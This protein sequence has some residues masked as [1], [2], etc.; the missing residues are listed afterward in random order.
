MR[1]D[2]LGEGCTGS[3]A[4]G[5]MGWRW[6]IITRKDMLHRLAAWDVVAHGSEKGFRI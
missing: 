5:V 1:I 6:W 2:I 3:C 4:A